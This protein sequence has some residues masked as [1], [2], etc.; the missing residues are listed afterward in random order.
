MF[1]ATHLGYGSQEINLKSRLVPYETIFTCHYVDWKAVHDT[2][3]LLGLS[4]VLLY[5]E[6]VDDWIPTVSACKRT[7]F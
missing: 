6:D 1:S 3:M 2:I 7:R 4:T 5:E